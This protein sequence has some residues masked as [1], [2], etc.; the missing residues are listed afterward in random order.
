MQQKILKITVSIVNPT[1]IENSLFELPK[2]NSFT[3]LSE[4]IQSQ[5]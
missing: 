3:M 1:E 4:L 2:R 5:Q